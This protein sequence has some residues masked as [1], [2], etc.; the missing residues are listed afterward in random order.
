VSAVN[1]TR[2]AV[3]NMIRGLDLAGRYS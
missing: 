2:R 3:Q 1:R